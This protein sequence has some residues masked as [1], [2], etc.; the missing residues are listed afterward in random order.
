[1]IISLQQWGLK[2]RQSESHTTESRERER[3][4]ERERFVNH[5]CVFVWDSRLRALGFQHGLHRQV[6]SLRVF[7]EVL[8]WPELILQSLGK[9]SHL[10][11]RGCLGFYLRGEVG[12]MRDKRWGDILRRSKIIVSVDFFQ[13]D[14]IWNFPTMSLHWFCLI[15]TLKE[16]IPLS[17]L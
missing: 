17:A 5:S 3:E 16:L 1:M 11:S 8:L 13:N 7:G 9:V 10:L 15:F 2:L 12:W 6:T 4:R 14:L